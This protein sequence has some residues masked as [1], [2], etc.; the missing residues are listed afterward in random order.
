MQMKALAAA[1]LALLLTLPARA[2]EAHEIRIAQQ[3]GI[4]YLPLIVLKEQHLVEQFARAAGLPDLTVSWWQ[5]SSATGMNDALLSRN[6][7]VASGG[8]APL[9]TLWARTLRGLKVRALATL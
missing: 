7:D 8:I 9:I 4:A 2:E 3:Y 1:A 6:L 5:F